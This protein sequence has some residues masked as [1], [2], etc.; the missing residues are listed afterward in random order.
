LNWSTEQI[1]RN[2]SFGR[3]HEHRGSETGKSLCKFFLA[4]NCQRV[5]CRFSHD[6]PTSSN[7]E[8][9]PHDE[10]EGNSLVDKS[11]RWNGPTWDE[12]GK[13]SNIT[14]ASGWSESI[15]ANRTTADAIALD[16][17]DNTWGH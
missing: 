9:R 3:D 14:K 2:A 13:I 4:G 6:G 7:H 8:S 17:M 5:N 10:G 12:V 11:G 15:D 16:K 1:S